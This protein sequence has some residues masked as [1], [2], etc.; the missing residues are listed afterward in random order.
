MIPF[1]KNLQNKSGEESIN[2]NTNFENN[3]RFHNDEAFKHDDY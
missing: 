2:N 3:I 1:L